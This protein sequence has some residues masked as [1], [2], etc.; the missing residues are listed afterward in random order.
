MWQFDIFV[1][2][3]QRVPLTADFPNLCTTLELF[4]DF[5]N[6]CK[7]NRWRRW[8]I[9]S[10]S[11]QYLKSN[12]RRGSISQ[13]L[14]IN[15]SISISQYQ[16]LNININLSIWQY[17]K[18]NQGRGWTTKRWHSRSSLRS[19]T[20]PRA[21]LQSSTYL[22]RLAE[23]SK[24]TYFNELDR[25][26]T[27]SGFERQKRWAGS[28]TSPAL[29]ASWASAWASGMLTV[30][31]C[32]WCTHVCLCVCV[33]VCV[34]LCLFL[35]RDEPFKQRCLCSFVSLAEILYHCF[36]C[37]SLFFKKSSKSTLVMKDLY[38]TTG[39]TE[40]LSNWPAPAS[41]SW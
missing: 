28:P 31:V 2:N 39:E 20:T 40:N 21:T 12:Q 19:T 18:S 8:V 16:Y 14:N 22:S 41:P 9:I 24:F 23:S 3:L 25:S 37:V 1:E 38:T 36:I 35:I 29:V 15:I 32:V 27:A 13:Y 34:L 33:S 7:N 17:L 26:R 4:P 5:L 10:Q 11:H 6:H 30:F